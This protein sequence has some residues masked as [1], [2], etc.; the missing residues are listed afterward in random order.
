MK[1]RLGIVGAFDTVDKIKSVGQKLDQ[2]ILIKTYPYKH[3]NETIEILKKHQNEVDVLLFSGQVPYFF[4]KGEGVIHKPAVYI[5]RTGTSV[6]RAFWQMRDSGI[7]YRKMSFDTIDEMAI[8]EVINELDI[9]MKKRFAKPFSEDID[10]DELLDFHYQLWKEKKINIAIT[11]ISKVYEQ[12]KERNVPVYKL[13]PTTSL[14]REHVNKA[15]YKGDVE[16]IKGTQIAVQI[17]KVKN[18]IQSMSSQYEFLKL[19]NKLEEGLIPYTQEN[20]GSLFPFG[21]DEYL[22][23]TTRGAIA[24][25][26]ENFD[27]VK[28]LQ[29]QD[30]S[31][32]KLASGIGF[33]NSVHEAEANARIALGYALEEERNSC[34]IVD[35]KGNI[36]GPIKENNDGALSYELAV[37]DKEMQEMAEQIKISATYISKI[38]SIIEKMGS[39]KMNAEEL[40]NY[41]GISIRSG[42]RI[43]K[44]MT[45]AGYGKVIATK[46]VASAGRPRQIYEILL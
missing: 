16:K 10:Y 44:Q 40:A 30:A 31:K 27:L 45:D 42:R 13:Y 29:Y 32:I 14:I 46:S 9:P 21:R 19:K 17:V 38:K 39:N 18:K 1:L 8:D 26:C 43:L 20:F 36:L 41:L 23:F 33:G 28:Y 24:K 6:Y 4:A 34:F 35:E 37:T 25:K 15:I 11:C 22:I 3:K 7:D 12:L 5:P 2:Q